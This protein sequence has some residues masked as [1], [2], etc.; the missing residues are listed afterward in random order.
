[1]SKHWGA[2]SVKRSHLYILW[3][4]DFLF[5]F[6]FAIFN[7]NILTFIVYALIYDLILFIITKSRFN[8]CS[9]LPGFI[10]KFF[11]WVLGRL[12]VGDEDPLRRLRDSEGPDHPKYKSLLHEVL[13]LAFLE[14]T[15]RKE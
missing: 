12:A 6:I 5:A 10:F 1:M 14:K 3:S 7:W 8:P 13:P 15:F 4:Y 2:F 11:G 9:R